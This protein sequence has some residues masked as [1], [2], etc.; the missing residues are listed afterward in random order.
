MG[1][2]LKVHVH[3]RREH[4]LLPGHARVGKKGRRV[5]QLLILTLGAAEGRSQRSHKG[6]QFTRRGRI[7]D[8]CSLMQFCCA[9]D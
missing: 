9:R 4:M 6:M 5:L 1:D 7:I 3:E 8:A 2:G